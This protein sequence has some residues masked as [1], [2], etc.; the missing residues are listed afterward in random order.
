M[1]LLYSEIHVAM[2]HDEVD[3]WKG[4]YDTLLCE[5]SKLLIVFL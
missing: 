2:K 4:G 5:K 3:L 1:V